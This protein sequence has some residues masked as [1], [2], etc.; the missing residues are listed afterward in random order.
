MLVH[1]QPQGFQCGP[2]VAAI[3]FDQTTHVGPTLV[4]QNLNNSNGLKDFLDV[5]T[6]LGPAIIPGSNQCLMGAILPN[7]LG[8]TRGAHGT[9]IFIRASDGLT[10]RFCGQVQMTLIIEITGN[11]LNS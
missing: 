1:E 9:V 5:A 2:G 10:E 4:S 11:S 7:F 6:E 3:R 8:S